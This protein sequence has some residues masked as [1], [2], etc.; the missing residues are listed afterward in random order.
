MLKFKT[1]NRL[2]AFLA[3]VLL[4]FYFAAVVHLWWFVF[5]FIFWFL[6]TAYGS[7]QIKMNYFL[8]AYHK[9]ANL[10]EKIVALTFDDGP[11][12]AYTPRV[13]ELL[14]KYKQ[15]ASFFCIGKQAEQHPEILK[16]IVAEGH[17]IGNHSYSHQDTYG[18]L[19]SQNVIKDLQKAQAVLF[20]I[21]G[22]RPRFFR[23][24]FGVT[25]PNIAKA[26][27]KLNLIT[28]GWQIR[29]FDT[30]AKNPDE[31]YRKIVK[32]LKNGDVILLHD[33]SELSVKVL[34]NL[35][36]YMQQRGIKS[37]RLD[38]LFKLNAYE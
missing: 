5:V 32:K 18:F 21:S 7:F 19:S 27:K 22:A 34:Q 36:K 28:F 17:L 3:L 15:K 14:T 1:I 20:D 4:V 9:K 35:L 38:T 24:P 6:I 12:A 2:F 33:T 29:S 26:V 25:N 31:V 10:D 8:P 16:Q 23:P 13:L 37:E 30:V 11:H